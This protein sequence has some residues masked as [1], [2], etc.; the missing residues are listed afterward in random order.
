MVEFRVLRVKRLW[1]KLECLVYEI[2]SFLDDRRTRWFAVWVAIDAGVVAT[3]RGV[4]AVKQ[5]P[6]GLDRGTGAALSTEACFFK[7]LRA[8]SLDETV[9]SK[10]YL[11]MLI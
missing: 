3:L 11:R 5:E 9:E 6:A 7:S 10:V 8:L 4:R 1:A 2:P